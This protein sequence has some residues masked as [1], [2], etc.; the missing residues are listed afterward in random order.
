MVQY[1]MAPDLMAYC[2]KSFR[3]WTDSVIFLT[4]F[5]ILSCMSQLSPVLNPSSDPAAAPV[6]AFVS[7]APYWH[8]LSCHGAL[9]S[10][11][12]AL[13]LSF[14]ALSGRF[15]FKGTLRPLFTYLFDQPAYFREMAQEFKLFF[16]HLKLNFCLFV[17][18]KLSKNIDAEHNFF[19]FFLI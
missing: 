1:K 6:S 14:C 10:C 16:I 7:R 3:P 5:T 18:E 15:P 2:D 4:C 19:V 8:P 13:T 11:A 12:L 17:F 9:V